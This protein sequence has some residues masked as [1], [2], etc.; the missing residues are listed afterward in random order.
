MGAAGGRG[1]VVG[2]VD[3]SPIEP[4]VPWKASGGV[5]EAGRRERAAEERPPR[6]PPRAVF[7]LS[8]S[9]QCCLVAFGSSSIVQG[10]ERTESGL[11]RGPMLRLRH[12]S[13]LTRFC[14]HL[15]CSV[16]RVGMRLKKE[17]SKGTKGDCLVFN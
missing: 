7:V 11:P 15:L 13:L 2:G 5:A 14:L 16:D 12:L 10:Y 1:G 17:T 3:S 8:A 9:L 6:A 4:G